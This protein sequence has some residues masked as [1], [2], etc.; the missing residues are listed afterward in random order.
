M[1]KYKTVS[2]NTEMYLAFNNYILTHPELG[3]ASMVEYVRE[4][5]RQSEW[6]REALTDYKQTKQA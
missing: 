5:L 1:P 6:A 2:I 4:A 3:Y